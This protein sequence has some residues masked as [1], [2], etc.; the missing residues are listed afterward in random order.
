MEFA[1]YNL[2][3]MDLEPAAQNWCC[4]SFLMVLL[5]HSHTAGFEIFAESG[6]FNA[7][8]LLSL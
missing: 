7:R 8:D 6:R 4:L 5:K 3:H 2:I 1:N